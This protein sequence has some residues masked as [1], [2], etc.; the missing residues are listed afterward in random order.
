MSQ[1]DSN[2]TISI[3]TDRRRFLAVA[4]ASVV[5]VGALTAVAMTTAAVHADDQRLLELEELIFERKH[6]ADELSAQD[7]PLRVIWIAE[8]RRL[9]DA[10]EAAGFGGTTFAEMKAIINAM[11][12]YRESIRLADLRQIEWDAQDQLIEEMWN[13]KAQTPEGRR[14]K[15]TVLLGVIMDDEEWLNAAVPGTTYDVVRARDLMIE[16]V[17]GEPGEQMRDQFTVLEMA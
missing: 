17:G 4:G 16:M 8:Q 13:I 15:L 12:E 6:A 1:T 11:P 14:A 2:H 10:F 3:D 5:S 9:H 7:A